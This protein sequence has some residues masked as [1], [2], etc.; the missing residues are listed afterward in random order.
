MTNQPIPIEQ[1]QQM[2]ALY[3]QYIK[4]HGIGDQTQYVIFT[5]K[6]FVP[7]FDEVKRYAD[8]FRIFNGVY[9]TGH[10]FAGRMTVIIWPYKDGKP[11]TWPLVEGKDGDPDPGAPIK[12][13]NDGHGAP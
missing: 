10:E 5:N 8:E 2:I 12:P 4:D 1:A 6:E 9:P 13:F 3:L 7:W 11:A